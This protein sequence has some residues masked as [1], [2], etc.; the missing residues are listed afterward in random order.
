VKKGSFSPQP[1]VD[2]AVLL[3][4]NI[5]KSFFNEFSEEDFFLI[6]K[7]GFSQKR[8]QLKNN[9]DE[10]F[11]ENLVSKAFSTCAIP[12]KARAEEL[13]LEEWKCLTEKLIEH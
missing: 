5:S 6:V 1:N 10:H 7:K 8:K 4:D 3:I 11:E 2:S 13:N 9:F 12:V